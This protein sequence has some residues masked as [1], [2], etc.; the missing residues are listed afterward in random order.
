MT[1]GVSGQ[2]FIRAEQQAAKPPGSPAPLALLHGARSQSL[3]V[4]LCLPAMM[5]TSFLSVADKSA[6]DGSVLDAAP[7]L[8]G[9]IVAAGG[10]EAPIG[11]EGD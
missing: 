3:I 2:G 5:G 11:G 10:E 1:A 6:T 8:D 4:L 7:E 9:V